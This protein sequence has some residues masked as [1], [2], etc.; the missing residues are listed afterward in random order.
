MIKLNLNIEERKFTIVLKNKKTGKSLI[1]KAIG[2]TR[3]VA[4]A[5]LL[6]KFKRPENYEVDYMT[7]AV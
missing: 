6:E 1:R 5:N 2:K 3:M 4:L 7:S